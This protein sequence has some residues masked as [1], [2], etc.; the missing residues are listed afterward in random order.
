MI[1][2]VGNESIGLFLDPV[3]AGCEEHTFVKDCRADEL[4]E[5]LSKCKVRYI[6]AE[7]RVSGT[8]LIK[9]KT[10]RKM[11]SSEFAMLREAIMAHTSKRLLPDVTPRQIRQALVLS[12]ITTKQIDDA[13][14][15]LKEPL[16]S[17]AKVEWEYSI[18]FQRNRPLVN[19]VGMVLGWTQK[20]IDDLW[21]LAGKL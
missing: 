11:S 19:Q 3:P 16:R 10:I 20:Q 18:S 12:G 7:L 2:I 17:L 5:D 21:I 9:I 13:F 6:L 14:N 1:N 4:Y 15:M 8:N